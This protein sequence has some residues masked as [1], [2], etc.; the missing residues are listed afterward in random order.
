MDE[1]EDIVEVLKKLMKSKEVGPGKLAS[2]TDVPSRFIDALLDGNFDQL[3]SQP[4]IR[5]YLFK[6][7][8]ALGTE[9]DYLWQIFRS[10]AE[11][12]SSGEKDLLP[13]NRFA[14]QKMGRLTMIWILAGIVVFL[15]VSL[16]FNRILGKPSIDVTVPDTIEE[17][18][19]TVTG[20]INPDDRLTLNEEIIYTNDIGAFEK[21]V[22]LE[23]GLNTLE[24]KVKRYLGRETKLVKQVFY[25]QP[26]IETENGTT[27][28]TI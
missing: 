26:I 13:I 20:T 18:V 12:L 11:A 8:T 23:P 14:L 5:G 6:I 16:N 2:L 10:S 25:Q 24:F 22:Q 27:Q 15:L 19:V 4:Y 1:I 17:S 21:Q 7:S 3:P 9:N 28:E